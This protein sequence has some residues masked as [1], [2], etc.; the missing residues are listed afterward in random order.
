MTANRRRA[1]GSVLI[2]AGVL[3]WVPFLFL[4]A[5]ADRP[6]IIPFLAAH[7]T[8][9]VGGGWLRASA[10]KLDGRDR[11]RETFG[12]RRKLVSSSMIYLGV[13]AWAPYFYFDKILGT[14]TVI[15][16]FLAAHLTG[17]LG[18]A[19]LRASVEVERW[20]KRG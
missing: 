9:V 5:G 2:W 13:L 8:G 4:L 12:R 18:G 11:A 17:V 19:A 15:T 16:P 7:L 1:I 14:E 20:R 6:S 10:D 3:A